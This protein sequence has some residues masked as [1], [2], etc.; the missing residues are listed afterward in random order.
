MEPEQPICEISAAEPLTPI[1]RPS[2]RQ[3]LFKAILKHELPGRS[4]GFMQGVYAQEALVRRL[5]LSST[6]TDHRGCVN[7]V[8]WSDDGEWLVSGS[9]D[10]RVCIWDY[11][12]RKLRGAIDTGHTANIFCTK[13][14][15][16]SD[17]QQIVSCAGDNLV[18]HLTINEGGAPNFAGRVTRTYVCHDGRTKK[19]GTEPLSSSF[20][21]SASEDGTIRQFDLREPH[22][23]SGANCNRTVLVDFRRGAS[24]LELYSLAVNQVDPNYFI[25]AGQDPL[26]RLFDRR[27]LSPGSASAG[28]R[29]QPVKRFCPR[30]YESQTQRALFSKGHITGVAYSNDGREVL[31]NYSG[32]AVYLFD[33]NDSPHSARLDPHSAQQAPKRKNRTPTDDGTAKPSQLSPSK[34]GGASRTRGLSPSA[35]G[36]RRRPGSADAASEGSVDAASEGK[37]VASEGKAVASEGKA[38]VEQPASGAAESTES[39]VMS[40]DEMLPSKAEFLAHRVAWLASEEEAEKDALDA[41]STAATGDAP[42]SDL[43]DEDLPD[44]AS[45]ASSDLNRRDSDGPDD[46]GA[47]AAD[48]WDDVIV[49]SDEEAG[50]GFDFGDEAD[51][52][53]HGRRSRNEDSESDEPSDEAAHDDDEEDDMVLLNSDSDS[54]ADSDSDAKSHPD[55]DPNAQDDHAA[56]DEPRPQ[57]PVRDEADS[58]YAG[59]YVG[60]CNVRTVKEVNFFG[61]RSEYVMSGSDDGNIFIWHKRTGEVVQL[62]H[63]DE[64]VVNCITGHPF[65]CVLASSGIERNVKLWTPTAQTPNPLTN[66]S[67]VIERNSERSSNT[68]HQYAIPL[69]MLRRMVVSMRQRAQ[70][71]GQANVAD[72]DS[73]DDEPGCAMQ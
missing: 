10:T 60:H 21:L 23:C 2:P 66:L 11:R 29:P 64:S 69:S 61:P 4:R 65:D 7:S 59:R 16:G 24:T 19:L 26:I 8:N 72:S 36:A 12:R 67:R 68:A 34:K 49:T 70:Q 73:D 42:S 52:R 28:T 38:E 17:N 14:M 50:L 32:D 63:G 35:V 41:A 46:S 3:N 30:T 62:L 53:D 56:D 55:A 43:D 5:E 31:G 54:N 18:K 71:E 27:M 39:A 45:E 57:A 6:L 40:D 25:C 48:S 9:D 47:G 22:T 58:S 33:I 37:D 13:F 1:S 51:E 20:V 44:R 15:P